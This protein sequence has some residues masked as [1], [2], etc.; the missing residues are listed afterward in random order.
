MVK[1]EKGKVGFSLDTSNQVFLYFI[2]KTT[3]GQGEFKARFLDRRISHREEEGG[4]MP[5]QPASRVVIEKIDGNLKRAVDQ[6]MAALAPPNFAGARVLIKPNM[7]GPSVPELGHTTHPELVREVVRSCLDRNGKVWVGDNPGGFNRSSRNVA[8]ITGLLAASEGCFIPL[9]DRV[10]EKK[11]PETG[12]QIIISRAILEADYII[13]L[14]VFKTHSGM[15]ITG[16]LKNTYGYV[17]GACKARLHVQAR[18]TETFAK[19]ICDVHQLRPPDLNLLDAITAIEG[20]GPCHG[21]QLREVGKL[22]ASADPLALDA[23]MARMMGVDPALLPVQK[24]ALVRG[25]G[26][27]Q[28]KEIEI[29][30]QLVPIPDFRMPVTFYASFQDEKVRAAL[31]KLYPRGMMETRLEIKP[32]RNDEKC[33]ACGDCALNCPAEALTLE[34]EFQISDQCIN[35]YCCVELCPEGAME[36]P[37]VEAFR[38]Y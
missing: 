6:V 38:H 1:K 33:I 23:V 17:A 32:V 20:N 5:V 30:G 21:G 8:K 12:F 10:V 36:V 29:L 27:L 24:E 26:V 7:V 4:P 13:N 3:N 2:S 18:N 28:E 22:L 9:S 11:G 31:K 37:D 25:L 35:C 19:T 15:M 16:A 34:P 14:P